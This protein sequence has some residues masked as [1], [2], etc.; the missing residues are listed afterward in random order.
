[1]KKRLLQLLLG[2]CLCT[3]ASNTMAITDSFYA[4]GEDLD[5]MYDSSDNFAIEDIENELRRFVI[6]RKLEDLLFD[7]NDEYPGISQ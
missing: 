6:Y 2:L 1:M 4:S 3:S 5:Y 7:F